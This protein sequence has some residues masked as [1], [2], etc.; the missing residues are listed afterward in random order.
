V[1]VIALLLGLK[2]TYQVKSP[3][4]GSLGLN[5]GVLR[6]ISYHEEAERFN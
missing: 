6:V 1:K 5:T 2:K 4:T 3:T